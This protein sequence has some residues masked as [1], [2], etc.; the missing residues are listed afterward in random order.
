MLSEKTVIFEKSLIDT[1]NCMF[2]IY[3]SLVGEESDS[4]NDNTSNTIQQE[5]TSF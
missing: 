4:K 5:P 3:F 2:L 1:C